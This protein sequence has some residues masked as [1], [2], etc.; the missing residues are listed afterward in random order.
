MHTSASKCF[1]Y[2][3][4]TGLVVDASRAAAYCAANRELE[5]DVLLDSEY[6]ALLHE[7]KSL[8]SRLERLTRAPVDTKPSSALDGAEIERRVRTILRLRRRREA[9]FGSDLF[10]EPA[11]DMLLELYATELAGRSES[12]TGLCCASGAPATTALRWVRVLENAGWMSRNADPLDGRRVFL[13]LTA[14][15]RAAMEGF[16]SQPELA[17]RVRTMSDSNGDAGQGRSEP[18]GEVRILA[19]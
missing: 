5:N 12:V 3:K 17:Q 4:L 11:W 15:A 19:E 2:D 16:L 10:G 1:F 8:Q 6:E 13:S 9:L 14:K 18:L 7:M